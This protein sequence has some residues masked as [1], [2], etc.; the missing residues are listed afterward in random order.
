M[1]TETSYKYYAF[2]SYNGNDERWAKWL[3]KKLEYY[4]IPS[5]LR[6]QHIGLP[7]HVRPVFWYKQDLS[8]T[9]LTS[10]L[11][12]E[13]E[14]SKYLIVICSPHSANSSWVNDEVQD[15]INQGKE[16]R[17]IPFIVEGIPYSNDSDECFP[18]A[19]RQMQRQEQLRGINIKEQGSDHALVDVIATMFGLR[20][21]DLWRRH[22]R[23]VI[24]NRIYMG[25]ACLMALLV[26]F[27]YWDYT[28]PTYEYYADYV[29]CNGI[30][31]GI[32]PLKKEE[33]EK[34]HQSYRFEKRRIPIGEPNAW[35]WR[36]AKVALIN[37]AGTVQE[38]TENEL[39]D[40]HP[41]QEIEYSDITGTV[42]R[43]N[44]CNKSGKT[45]LRHDLSEHN[46]T[47][48]CIADFK[49]ELEEKGSG[50][51]GASTTDISVSL[52][53]DKQNKTNIKRYAYKRNEQGFIIEQSFHSNNDDDLS[54]SAV[55]D[56]D[57]I[58]GMRYTLDSL[59]RRIKTEYLG[60]NRMP[61]S[62]KK[63][64]AGKTYEYD[65]FG[66]ICM[67]KYTNINGRETLNQLMWAKCFATADDNGNIIDKTYY[68]TEGKPC[69]QKVN[70]KVFSPIF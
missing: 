23:R 29:D 12:K 17:I 49:A 58:F 46:G 43:I 7:K 1:A 36:L 26:G 27:F 50:Y 8:G 60:I 32:L 10:S 3:H 19:L 51:I 56:G 4:K 15:F 68:G 61:F 55:S 67:V 24:R 13:L 31:K 22:R 39:K 25:I 52:L 6:K 33:V 47:P 18:P 5:A 65:R 63:G 62:T 66:N 21:D 34:R 37:S 38:H 41:I 69:L 14:A 11:H 70:Y 35:Q 42:I 48:A 64:I 40:R 30:P 2:I 54:R 20:F 16:E 57:G 44:Y 53:S 45:V 9:K 28:R 59:G